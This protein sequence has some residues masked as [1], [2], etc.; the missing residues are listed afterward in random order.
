MLRRRFAIVVY[1]LIRGWFEFVAVILIAHTALRVCGYTDLSDGVLIA[2][3][4]TTTVTVIGLFAVVV[5]YLFPSEPRRA[6]RRGRP[7]PRRDDPG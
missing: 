1:R 4:G 3:L 5:R 7:T 2:L 6:G